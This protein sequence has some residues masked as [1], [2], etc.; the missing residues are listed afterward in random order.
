MNTSPAYSFNPLCMS[1]PEDS[2]SGHHFDLLDEDEDEQRRLA[3][4]AVNAQQQQLRQH[5]QQLQQKLLH[6][7]SQNDAAAVREMVLEA[8]VKVNH[9]DKF[10]QSFGRVNMAP[11]QEGGASHGF[12]KKTGTSSYFLPPP[13]TTPARWARLKKKTQNK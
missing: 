2:S 13:S 10:Y 8:E 3:E 11:G 7:I 5:Q 12:L 1:L 9:V 6:C 4:E